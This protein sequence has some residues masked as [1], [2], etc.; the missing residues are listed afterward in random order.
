MNN[1]FGVV[2]KNRGRIYYFN[3]G[4]KVFNI[5]DNVIVETEAGLQYG[6]VVSHID[7]V[8]ENIE[9]KNLKPTFR[10]SKGC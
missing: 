9:I 10:K 8:K 2:F 6:K 7:I 1:V 3:A 4:E 5:N